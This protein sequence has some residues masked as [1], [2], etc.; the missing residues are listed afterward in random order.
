MSRVVTLACASVLIGLAGCAVEPPPSPVAEGADW[1]GTITSEDDLTRVTN[2]SG[3][4]WRGTASLVEEAS[5]GTSFGRDPYMFGRVTGVAASEDRIYVTDRQVPA[6][7]VYDRDGSHLGD[8]GRQGQGPGEYQSAS[9]VGVD[10]EQRVWLDDMSGARVLVFSSEG[11]PLATLRKEPPL[12]SGTA[13]MV[14]VPGSLAYIFSLV[15]DEDASRR[16]HAMRPYGIDGSVGDIVEFP[17][18][19]RQPPSFDVEDKDSGTVW[20][21]SAPYYPRGVSVFTPH[22]AMLSGF[23]DRYEFRLDYLDGQTLIVRRSGAVVPVPA[24]EAS[25]IERAA[26]D[27]FKGVDP[28]WRWPDEPLPEAKP[29]YTDLVPAASGEFWVIRSGSSHRIPD[30]R[31]ADFEPSA[32]PRCWREE[33]IVDVFGSDGRFLGDVTVPDEVAF[34]PRPFIRGSDVIA[35]A[36]DEAGTIMVKRYRLVL[37]GEGDR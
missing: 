24:G 4:I 17:T 23:P 14:V 34:S 31:E 16:R 29:A 32:K 3:S 11:K 21:I 27:F 8:I 12:V 20:T 10:D 30:C 1:V 19:E 33:R 15:R 25:A 18:F 26:T 2:E 7:R 22:P 37:P 36:E 5:I 13:P 28:S 35:V 9:S 6:L